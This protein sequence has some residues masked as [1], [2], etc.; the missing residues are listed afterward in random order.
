MR[1]RKRRGVRTAGFTLIEL[2]VVIGIIA[3][4][5]GILLPAMARAREQSKATTCLSQLR[6]IGMAVVMYVNVNRGYFPQNTHAGPGQSWLETLYPHGVRPAVRLCPSDLRDPPPAPPNGTS[7]ATNNY[8][9]APRPYALLTRVRRSSDTI[10]AAETRAS[11]DHLHA[12]GYVLAADI[13]KEIAVERHFR[14][15]N[16]LY[17]DG[18][19]M[20]VRYE[21]FVKTFTAE[22]SPFNPATAR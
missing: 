10:Y 6:Q 5:I 18:H 16:Y 2:L 20:T 8:T 19:A 12:T 13:A 1:K 17:C 22:T 4:L 14:A 3:V 21:Q 7:Y 9:V 15:A 11:G